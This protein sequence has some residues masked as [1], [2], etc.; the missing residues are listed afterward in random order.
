MRL[1]ESIRVIGKMERRMEEVSLIN[2]QE[3]A[4]IQ[5]VINMKVNGQ[6]IMKTEVVIIT[7][8]ILGT[9]NYKNGNI[10]I[11]QWNNGKREGN[12]KLNI[13]YRYMSLFKWRKI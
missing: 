2:I 3:L 12:G 13:E 6:M 5:M 9:M 7:Y 4:T 11:G 10:Y 1:V 8:N